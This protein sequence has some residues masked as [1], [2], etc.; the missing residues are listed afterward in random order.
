MKNLDMRYTALIPVTMNRA[1]NPA[2]HVI[3][4]GAILN[5]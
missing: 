2:A 4:M 5:I 1:H 3:V